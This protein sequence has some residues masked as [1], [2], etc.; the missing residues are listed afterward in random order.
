MVE[1][2]LNYSKLNAI[3]IIC[4]VRRKKEI[5]SNDRIKISQVFKSFFWTKWLGKNFIDGQSFINIST[6]QFINVCNVQHHNII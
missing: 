2:V 5:E 1:L 6:H 3:S 4:E